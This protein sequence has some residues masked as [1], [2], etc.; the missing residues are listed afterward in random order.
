MVACASS[1]L[2]KFLF[3]LSSCLHYTLYIGKVKGKLKL[4]H[5]F[6]CRAVPPKP[7]AAEWSRK[8]QVKR[9]PPPPTRGQGNTKGGY[10]LAETLYRR[11]A[12]CLM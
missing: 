5:L 4:F 6:C 1:N 10:R 11:F 9:K 8:V 2:C 7:S 3:S 12:N